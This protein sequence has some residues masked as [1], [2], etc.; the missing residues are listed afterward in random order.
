MPKAQ[1]PKPG[2]RQRAEAQAAADEALEQ[3]LTF[4]LRREVVVGRG[5]NRR[6]L[7]ES[8][9]LAVNLLTMA[10]KIAV[11][12]ATGLPFEAFWGESAVGEDSL[13]VLWWLARRKNGEA[14]LSFQ[15]AAT[16]WPTGVDADEIDLHVGAA[17]LE[18]DDPEA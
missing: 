13:V 18:A 11:R 1:A 16:Q 9:T 10:D 4:T 6:V 3:I 8:H 14:L 15:E 5:E 7:P 12:K 2:A 17:D